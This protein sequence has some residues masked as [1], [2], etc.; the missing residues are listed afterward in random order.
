MIEPA[1]KNDLHCTG[2]GLEKLQISEYP[3]DGDTPL[4]QHESII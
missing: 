3:I 4:E 2:S 1:S